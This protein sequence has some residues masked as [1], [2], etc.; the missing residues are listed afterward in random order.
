MGFAPFPLD[1]SSSKFRL[2]ANERASSKDR[3]RLLACP[4]NAARDR[5]GE[6]ARDAARSRE[7]REALDH[8]WDA[9]LC[10]SCRG[11]AMRYNGKGRPGRRRRR[12]LSYDRRGPL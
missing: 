11:C 5:R 1:A 2:D 8:V 7:Q 4:L 12:E 10:G 3:K 9:A 6:G